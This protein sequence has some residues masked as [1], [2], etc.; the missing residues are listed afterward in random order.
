[1]A[2][3]RTQRVRVEP[4]PAERQ[5]IRELLEGLARVARNR[6][7]RNAIARTLERLGVAMSISE[8]EVYPV[9]VVYPPRRIEGVGRVVAW[10]ELARREGE[11]PGGLVL[12][13]RECEH[14]RYATMHAA[15]RDGGITWSG[16]WS[17]YAA[18]PAAGREQFTERLAGE[19]V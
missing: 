3:Q 15:T 13:D 4:S 10:A 1:M 12:V 19:E 16:F 11:Y 7:A 17:H 2:V 6:D 9:E 8:R 5:V 14:D 18:T